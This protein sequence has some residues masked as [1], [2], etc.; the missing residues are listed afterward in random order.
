MKRILGIVGTTTKDK[1]TQHVLLHTA[2]IVI[3]TAT[4]SFAVVPTMPKMWFLN[5]FV[6]IYDCHNGFLNDAVITR[7]DK[8]DGS[9]I[10]RRGNYW[11]ILKKYAPY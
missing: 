5:H 9:Q 6:I 1:K 2:F 10:T 7:I 3:K 8:I 4:H 11:I